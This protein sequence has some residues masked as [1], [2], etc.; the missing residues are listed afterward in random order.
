MAN[1]MLAAVIADAVPV[2]LADRRLVLAFPVDSAFLR[3]KADDQANRQAVADAIRAVTGRSLA[4][5]YDL[6][7][8]PGATGEAPPPP[9][10]EEE[11]IAR[12]KAE[13]DAEELD[14]E[15][16]PNLQR[17]QEEPS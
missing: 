9:L 6:R 10:T 3:K 16:P 15:L 4:L 12:L 2:E 13:F 11:W 5:A 1:R 7:E 8:L 14:G 17:H